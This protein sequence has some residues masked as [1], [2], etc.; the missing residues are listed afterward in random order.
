MLMG[1]TCLVVVLGM[2][3]ILCLVGSA[4][5]HSMLK[6]CAKLSGEVDINFKCE[7]FQ[8]DTLAG[9]GKTDVAKSTSYRCSKSVLPRS[10]QTV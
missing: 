10:A 6:S 3:L 2:T 7:Y 5:A 1:M 4:H 9:V 8:L